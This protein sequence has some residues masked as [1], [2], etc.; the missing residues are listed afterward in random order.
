MS[1]RINSIRY[2]K[3]TGDSST[4][5][6]SSKSIRVERGLFLESDAFLAV[7]ESS[8]LLLVLSFCA[9]ER[10][11]WAPSLTVDWGVVFVMFIARLAEFP[12]R[13]MTRQ[14]ELLGRGETPDLG[15]GRPPP[16]PPPPPPSTAR[17]NITNVRG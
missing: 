4:S 6:R 2:L 1:A 14:A 7:R 5:P 13:F 17:R 9:Q 3:L 10:V 11:D 12:V 15:D 16:R 8:S